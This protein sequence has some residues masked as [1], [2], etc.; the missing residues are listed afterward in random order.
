ML[1]F[2]S[3]SCSVLL[4][5]KKWAQIAVLILC[6][7]FTGECGVSLASGFNLIKAK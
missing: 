1:V 3:R 4:Q 2:E 5:N 6:E 7:L